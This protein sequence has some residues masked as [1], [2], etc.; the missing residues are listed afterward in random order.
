MTFPHKS[1]VIFPRIFCRIRYY[2]TF[3]FI[4]VSDLLSFQNG[5]PQPQ[6][7]PAAPGHAP[8]NGAGHP[9]LQSVLN[10]AAALQSGAY[11]PAGY[12]P[13]PG[14]PG[15]SPPGTEGAP[16]MSSYW[17]R[18][19]PPH[20]GQHPSPF[21]HPGIKTIPFSGYLLFSLFCPG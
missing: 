3:L 7:A 9:G 15:H 17:S 1:D 13:H 10:A 2:L 19:A 18:H 5:F 14:H 4:A 8:S 16:D 11:S 12:R 20:P 6:E 21:Q